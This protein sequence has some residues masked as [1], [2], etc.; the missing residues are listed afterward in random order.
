MVQMSR[1]RLFGGYYLGTGLISGTIILS[2]S[3]VP[4]VNQLISCRNQLQ[5]PIYRKR[6]KFTV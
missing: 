6:S 5:Y 4:S 1:I 3:T 2:T